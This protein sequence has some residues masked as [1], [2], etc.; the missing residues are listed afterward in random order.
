MDEQTK[1]LYTETKSE[2]V[3]EAS[4]NAKVTVEVST[5]TLGD[6]PLDELPR[7]FFPGDK[8]SVITFKC[9]GS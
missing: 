1:T 9:S 8:L 6:R 5:M 2:P 4:M 3:T 7:G